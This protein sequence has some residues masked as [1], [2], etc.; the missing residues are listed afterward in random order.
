MKTNLLR[1]C[2]I[3]LLFTTG[4]Y[5]QSTTS[6]TKE[7]SSSERRAETDTSTNGKQDSNDEPT[8][9]KQDIKRK[10][11]VAGEAVDKTT[12]KIGEVVNKG[13]DKAENA[14]VTE[15]KKIKAKRAVNVRRDT[16]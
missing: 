7:M 5:A 12:K 3:A 15:G 2:L 14:I 8:S 9:L 1:G 16:L 11:K 10:A 4:A 13:L 6:D